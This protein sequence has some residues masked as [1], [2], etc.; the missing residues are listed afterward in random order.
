MLPDFQ[1]E[2]D[3]A[4]L[5]Y[6]LKELSLSEEHYVAGIHL[7]HKLI[8]FLNDVEIAGKKIE[9]GYVIDPEYHN[10]GYATEV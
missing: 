3:A 2:E 6:R 5:F 8:G 1:S 4:K 9:L 10:K 7:D